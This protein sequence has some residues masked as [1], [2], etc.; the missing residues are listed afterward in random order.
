LPIPIRV[1]PPI[2]DNERVTNDARTHAV[3]N[4]DTAYTYLSPAPPSCLGSARIII[5]VIIKMTQI[6]YISPVDPI[7]APGS[8][9]IIIAVNNNNDVRITII[10]RQIRRRINNDACNNDKDKCV[11]TK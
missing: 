2:P 5:N 6:D 3:A 10:I 7:R 8:L 11:R 1:P 9:I 4:S